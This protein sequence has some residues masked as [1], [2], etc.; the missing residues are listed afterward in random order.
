[1]IH[2]AS[3]Y[4]T[5][6]SK[7]TQ[8]G[9]S[10]FHISD[11]YKYCKELDD[12]IAV[13]KSKGY[14][15]CTDYQLRCLNEYIQEQKINGI[16]ELT[17]F[18]YMFGYGGVNNL[19]NRESL[20]STLTGSIEQNLRFTYLNL[21][22]PT[23]FELFRTVNGASNRNY[24]YQT[25]EG[26]KT[27]TGAAAD[28]GYLTMPVLLGSDT[29]NYSQNNAAFSIF[30]SSNVVDYP[31]LINAICFGKQEASGTISFVASNGTASLIR[32]NTSGAGA[33][34]ISNSFYHGYFVGDRSASNLTTLYRD[35]VSLG[36][37]TRV[38]VALSSTIYPEI[39][40]LAGSSSV[41]RGFPI[42]ILKLSASL[43]SS[44]QK[45]DYEIFTQFR[46]KL[47]YS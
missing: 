25:P 13:A 27:G 24:P 2:T 34:Q 37:T 38:S 9:S 21:K 45:T 7:L 29:V 30:L 12:V 11:P 8:R 44:L 17:D 6:Q 39:L 43:G 14:M 19:G 23:R 26:L 10:H 41:Y 42:G 46:T 32:I 47:G 40:R 20:P 28:Y 15:L 3:T 5:T 18:A 36:T 35:G 4:P 31:T 16:W 22:D 33:N 1:M